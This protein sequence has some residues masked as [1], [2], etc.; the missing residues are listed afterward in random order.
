W[1]AAGRSPAGRLGDRL[2]RGGS[3]ARGEALAKRERDVVG[4]PWRDG[5]P[6]LA[7]AGARA[8]GPFDLRRE[9]LQGRC[10]LDRDPAQVGR[11][12][13]QRPP[14]LA[15]APVVPDDPGLL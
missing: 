11:R 5:V 9:A 1:P 7:K 3:L 8:P 2:A 10:L 14:T 13:P 4:E 15:Q 12:P 6:D